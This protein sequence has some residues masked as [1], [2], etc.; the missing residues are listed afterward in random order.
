[1]YGRIVDGQRLAIHFTLSLS[2]SLPLSL[3]H[4]L[5]NFE[6]RLVQVSPKWTWI[7]CVIWHVL[8]L[9]MGPLSAV[10][11]DTLCAGHILSVKTVQKKKH[12]VCLIYRL[13]VQTCKKNYSS[14]LI[15]CC[16]TKH[17]GCNIEG[18]PSTI[19]TSYKLQVYVLIYLY[20]YLYIFEQ[21]N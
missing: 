15:S 4:T 17:F 19:Y 14:P 9:D 13:A 1:M 18:L 7:K 20:I 12:T 21:K 10:N 16:N 3:T 5:H 6:L 11:L 8:W 2:L